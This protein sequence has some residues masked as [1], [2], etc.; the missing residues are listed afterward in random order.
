MAREF[1]DAGS[2]AELIVGFT[3]TGGGF[4]AFCSGA[5]VD[6]V[7]ASRP[8]TAKEQAACQAIGR[9]PIGFQI[10]M[11]ALAVVV[12]AANPFAKAL[13]LAQLKQIYSG[14]AKTWAEIDPSFPAT[15]IK[16]Y[17]PGADSGTFDFFV[18]HVMGGNKQAVLELPGAVLS[19]DDDAL[20]AGGIADPYAIGYFGYAYYKASRGKLRVLAI[21]KGNGP[22]EPGANTA[23]NG[24]YPLARPLFIYTS[25]DLLRKKPVVAA[26]VSYYLRY[27]DL[28]IDDVGYFPSAPVA[29]ESAET[30]LISALQ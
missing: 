20:K 6:I 10:G 9:K 17:S 30:A 14:Q 23:L 27:V 21:D 5:P 7:D 2:K 22:I 15:P 4:R 13:T 16:I 3:G 28:Q 29:K 26:F 25:S 1:H 24:T 8:I 18:E 19:E 12:S 11:D